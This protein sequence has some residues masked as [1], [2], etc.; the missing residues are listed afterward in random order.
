LKFDQDGR[1]QADYYLQA[2][3][4]AGGGSDGD[5]WPIVDVEL[6]SPTNSNRRATASQVINCT[7]A[8]AERVGFVTQRDVMLYGNGAMRDL[9]INDRMGC[10]WLWCPR[11]TPTL[12]TFIYE[13]AG[14]TAEELALWQY[15]GD[16]AGELATTPSPRPTER[17]STTARWSCRV[18]WSDF[19]R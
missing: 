7:T 16:G 13:R 8:F 1:A 2:V 9:G 4:A 14:W 6:V 17:R 10:D 18:G 11:Y 3:D 12:P 15:A 5:L 19:G